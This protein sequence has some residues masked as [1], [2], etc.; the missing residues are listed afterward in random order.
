MAEHTM[1]SGGNVQQ[2]VDAL[3][4]DLQA[5]REDF[6][7]FAKH[8]GA[9]AK[10]GVREAGARAGTMADSLAAKGR[11][12][13]D[14]VQMKIEEHPF[15]AVGIALGVGLLIGAALSRR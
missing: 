15:A 2:H 14:E 12:T 5:L 1:A 11:D 6:R 8:A 10:S 4:T 13:R 9:A 7:E 3:K